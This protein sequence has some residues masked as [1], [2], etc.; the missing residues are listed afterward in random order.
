[1]AASRLQNWS[2]FLGAFNYKIECIRTK[3]NVVADTLSRL[4]SKS[5]EIENEI[6]KTERKYTYL[7]YVI[8]SKIVCLDYKAVARETAKDKNLALIKR[9]VENGWPE[10]KV[11]DWSD[12]L[13]AYALRKDEITIEKECLMWGQRVIIPVKLQ[14]D[15]IDKLHESHF[16]IVRMKSMARSIV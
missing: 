5:S 15:V 4:P 6:L 2:F 13:K 12:E 11:R 16:G 8:H 1:M 10:H 14:A 7:H 3:E 9:M